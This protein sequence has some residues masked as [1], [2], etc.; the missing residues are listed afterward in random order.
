MV[1]VVGELWGNVCGRW[2]DILVNIDTDLIIFM[3]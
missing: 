2:I 1:C 3:W